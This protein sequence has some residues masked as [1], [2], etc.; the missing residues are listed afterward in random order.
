MHKFYQTVDKENE[1]PVEGKVTGTI[2]PWIR[3]SLYRNGPGMYEVGDTKFNHLFDP[4]AMFQRFH[5]SDGKAYYQCR[6]LRSDT[7]KRNMAA[8]R[9]VVTE[10]G[11]VAFPDP[12]KNIF[13]RFLSFF[14][15]NDG[16]SDNTLVSFYPMKDELYASTESDTIHKVDPET[17]DSL[18]KVRI[19]KYVA[20]NMA[21]AHPHWDIDGTLH[22]IGY[23]FAKGPKVCLIKFPPKDRPEDDF[24]HG[25]VV[26][27]LSPSS[28]FSINYFHSFAMTENYYIFVAQPV[29]IN[30]LKVLVGYFRGVPPN[31]AIEWWP[32]IKATFRV[33]RKSTGEEVCPNMTYEA[34]PFMVFHHCNAYEDNDHIVI[35][36]CAHKSNEVFEYFNLKNLQGDQSL[37]NWRKIDNPEPRRYILPLNIEKKMPLRS[38]LVKLTNTEAS[39][40]LVNQSAIECKYE[41]LASIGLEFPQIHY[42]KYNTKKYK[43]LYGVGWHKDGK[44]FNT[45]AKIDVKNKTYI[46]WAEDNAYPSEPVFVPDPDG[47]EEDDG[48]LMSAVNDTDFESGK[49]AF[50]LILNAKTMHELARVH[51]NIP[52]FPKDFHGLFRNA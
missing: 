12:C 48:I 2:P 39:A 37:E 42:Q 19:S 40:T 35:D 23:S 10:V 3:G 22:N 20:V 49:Q 25:E 27:S 33:I 11:T 5:V 15:P 16:F 6:Y 17:L 13:R 29:Y 38:N 45:L 30:L 51:F 43:Y 14:Q 26:A 44:H 21:T 28:K 32:D 1:E 8:K 31:A 36:L 52:R 24:P 47:A 50:L 41:K 18:G 4:M 34:D 46:E 9:I 7:Y